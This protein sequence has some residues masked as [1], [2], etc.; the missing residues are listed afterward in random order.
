LT[1]DS[2]IATIQI[3][4]RKPR[5]HFSGAFYHVIV[6]GNRRQKIFKEEEDYNLYL[7]ILKQNTERYRVILYAYVLMQN[8]I[9]LLVEVNDI[10][11]SRLMQNLQF[12][13]TRNFNIK[14]HKTGHLFQGRYK[15]ILCEK[16]EYFLELSAY[17]HLNPVRAGMV[18]DPSRYIWSS[19]KEY[20]RETKKCLIEKQAKDF[21]LGQFARTRASSRSQY[22]KF[23][24]SHLKD[25]HQKEMYEVTDQRFLG[26][27]EFIEEIQKELNE[28][29]SESY[30]I[31]LDEIVKEVSRKMDIS[32]E[33]INSMRRSRSGTMGRSV[34]AYLGRELCHY[35]N[36]DIANYFNREPSA[37]SQG[38]S[39]V[40]KRI[41]E[42]IKFEKE[43]LAL[44]NILKRGRKKIIT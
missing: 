36:K 18:A 17:I 5:V 29:F 14:Y 43:M 23:V 22:E 34:V 6:R 1:K 41:I 15:A 9:H 13:Y 37:I 25:G 4:A 19:Y 33:I 27:E 24:R 40:E 12:C 20:I 30:L 31:D 38:V 39:K 21:V 44:K 32:R 42:E 8:H 3:M 35:K 10:P 16:D 26:R 11:L 7:E 2:T 28:E